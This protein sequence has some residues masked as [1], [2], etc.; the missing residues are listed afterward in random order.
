MVHPA[1]TAGASLHDPASGPLHLIFLVW[2]V[3]PCILWA[4]TLISLRCLPK[5]HPP[6]E[7][8]PDHHS[9][10]IF[11]PWSILLH[12]TFYQLTHFMR[13]YHLSPPLEGKFLESSNLPVCP[14]R[15][16]EPGQGLSYGG[17]WE[18]SY[19]FVE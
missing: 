5:C 9:P 14:C 3:V 7:N 4:A 6:V 8:F 2:N 13:V 10:F 18:W 12:H 15:T 16:P 17:G 19:M 1:P 11:S